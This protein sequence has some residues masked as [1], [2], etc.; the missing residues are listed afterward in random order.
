MRSVLPCYP[1]RHRPGVLR[2]Y[3]LRPPGQPGGGEWVR[4]GDLHVRGAWPGFFPAVKRGGVGTYTVGFVGRAGNAG[5]VALLSH[6]VSDVVICK[7]RHSQ[8]SVCA[9]F[10]FPFRSKPV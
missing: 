8:S 3:Q 6:L 10:F 7:P 4:R 2:C 1:Q 5:N 9:F